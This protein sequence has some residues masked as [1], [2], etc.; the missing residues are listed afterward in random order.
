M[1]GHKKFIIRKMELE[2]LEFAVQLAKEEGWNPGIHDAECFFASD[3][4]GFFVGELIEDDGKENS[5]EKLA[6]GA[7][8]GAGSNSG[9]AGGAG[10]SGSDAGAAGAGGSGAGGAG[11]SSGLAGGA[12]GAGSSS[13]LAGGAGVSEIEAKGAGVLDSGAGAID[14]GK[15]ATGIKKERIAVVSAVRYG[16]EFAF[17][18]FYIVKP[19]YRKE[20]YG[21]QISR[22][23][24]NHVKGM[25]IGIDG[26]VQQQKNYVKDGYVFYMNQYRY[27]GENI[28]GFRDEK[29]INL[30]SYPFE[31][32]FDYDRKVVGYKREKFLNEWIH[33]Q[34][35]SALGYVE[36][37]KL[38]GMGVIRKCFVGYKVGMLFADDREIAEKIFYA[39]AEK[40]NGEKIYLD[41][42]EKN[43]EA[44]EFAKEKLGKYVFETARMYKNGI[45]NQDIGKIFGVTTFEL[46]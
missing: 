4:D 46:G 25:L 23:A 2:D 21:W 40:A 8:S 27:E 38:K 1:A 39:L 36:D 18:G 7:G 34:G 43:Y 29:I 42:P 15:T 6:G 44:Y 20:G 26:V 16:N 24:E 17:L 45:L 32:V 14:T 10:I 22:Y 31:Q 5:E 41:V 19:E 35:I 9:L 30:Q 37:G 3:P 12:G 13:G 28:K 33:Q 11:S